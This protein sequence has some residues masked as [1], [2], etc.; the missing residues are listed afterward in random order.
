MSDDEWTVHEVARM[1]GV[2]VR[3]LHHYDQIGLLTP[4]AVSA[5]GYRLYNTANLRRLQTI[6]LFREL[7]FPLRQIKEI[8]DHP[9]FD[10]VE[11]IDQQ[12][13]LLELQRQH[14]DKVIDLAKN[15][16]NTHKGGN[17][18]SFA[19]FDTSELRQYE[20][21]VKQRWGKTS[22]YQQYVEKSRDRQ[23]NCSMENMEQEFL[24]LFAQLGASRCLN[25][26]DDTVRKQ[27]IALR[28]F[29]TEHYFECT[30]EILRGLG[31]MYVQDPRFTKTIDEAG[32]AGTAAFVQQVIEAMVSDSTSSD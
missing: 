5:A 1:T 3:A 4:A 21:E 11:A 6:L 25:P 31:T 20:E 23:A 29:I 19:A 14:L 9:D 17:M 18:N 13:H 15:M 28:D 22:A 16:R 12:I 32:G 27:V 24:A 30:N 7:R 8:L 10:Q 2:T 26:H